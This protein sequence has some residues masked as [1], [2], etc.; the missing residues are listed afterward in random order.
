MT[1]V[2][3]HKVDVA[4]I[5]GAMTGA[6]L[7]LA[8][9]KLTNNAVKIALIEAKSINHEHQ[10][11]DARSI[12]LSYGS[13]ALLDKLG[14][15]QD[16]SSFA[17]AINHIHVSD[18]G[19]AGMMHFD[20]KDENLPFLGQVIELADAGQ[21]LYQK[22]AEAPNISLFCPAQVSRI[23]RTL[24]YSKL[25]LDDGTEL[26][27]KLAVAA[28]GGQSTSCEMLGIA[29]VE[30]DFDQV[31][32]ISNVVADQ[33]HQHRA[34]ERFTEQGP[35]ALL[36]MSKERCSLVWC[37]RPE[38]A[39]RIL[40][41]D[42]ETFLSELQQAFGWRLG[43]IKQS[44][45]PHS[46]P[47]ILRQASKLISHRAA[48]VGN[49]AQTLHP[50]AGQG[51]NLG[52]RDVMTLATEISNAHLQNRDIGAMATLQRYRENREQDRDG[53][54]RLISSLVYGFSNK[55][56]PIIAARNLGLMAMSA[57]KTIKTPLMQH[58]MGLNRIKA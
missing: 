25:F 47:L 21:A 15:W 12:A 18:T 33:A 57:S 5:G 30:H 4:I 53:T 35:V 52:L 7:A 55:S 32:I 23:E 19:H 27:T 56:L 51:F 14:L 8:I 6:T 22:L 37:V 29:R 45:I 43:K 39:A 44:S 28:D 10:G 20:A 31:A 24:D 40:E 58:M 41:L 48:V 26:T 9:S 49:A 1:S 2:T 16:F 36:P 50:I 38:Q 42:K 13:C 54:V 46:Y 17:T 34:F 11:F 3:T